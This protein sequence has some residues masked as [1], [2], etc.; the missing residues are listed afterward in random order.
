MSH[1]MTRII[2]A[3]WLALPLAACGLAET[4]V[5][6]AALATSATEAAKQAQKTE[7]QVQSQ[8]EA[9]QQLAAE[10][11]Q[12]AEAASDSTSAQ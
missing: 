5:T 7:Q 3:C 8:V 11:L 4:A 2:C 12:A 6:G 9:A 1:N 10:K